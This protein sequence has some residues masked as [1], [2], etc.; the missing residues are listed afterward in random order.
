M[1]SVTI[2]ILIF[3]PFIILSSCETPTIGHSKSTQ[4]KQQPSKEYFTPA[5]FKQDIN[6]LLKALEQ[7]QLHPWQ[8]QTRENFVSQLHRLEKGTFWLQ[9]RLDVY[10][11]LAP[12]IANFNE[13]HTRLIYPHDLSKKDGFG[14]A[15]FP[16]NVQYENNKILVR[17]D[18]TGKLIIPVGAQILSINGLKIDAILNQM[19]QFIPQETITGSNR[20]IEVNF[21]QL[22]TREIGIK[23]DFEV[24]WSLG[25]LSTSSHLPAL[26]RPSL[27]PRFSTNTP[28][29]QQKL[30]KDTM[31]VEIS[32][33]ESNPNTFEI[34]LNQWFKKIK[35][36]GFSHLIF[37][38]RYNS[39][40][41]GKNVLQLLSHL[42]TKPIQW[43][44]SINIKNSQQFRAFNERRLKAIK[45]QK[46]GKPLRWL[47]IE[48]LNG[49]NWQLLFTKN[50]A[51]IE[52]NIS[53]QTLAEPQLRFNGKVILLS[54]GYCF[55]GC[56]FFV[57]EIKKSGRGIIIGESPGSKVGVQYGYPIVLTFPNSHLKLMLPVALIKQTS[58]PY[59]LQP[60]ISINT[61]PSD[62]AQG[63]DKY[64]EAA[65]KTLNH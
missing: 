53:P 17:E 9:S 24:Q 36:Q 28:W 47:P 16:L 64:L 14:E 32:D 30:S 61:Q 59:V 42:E 25:Y 49:W 35:Q 13:T 48:Y 57:N 55:S 10:R 29:Q 8:Q 34:F 21:S 33:F 15:I 41:I 20:Q 46:F 27:I 1:I 38:L 65:L 11:H 6:F 58:K 51:I 3:L 60:D 12:L 44:K 63:R 18:L 22:L 4:I 37:D 31:L 2:R 26:R 7:T 52:E 23:P 40:G 45:K 5:E 39:G 54:N 43:A 62:L 19:L 56:A 50:G